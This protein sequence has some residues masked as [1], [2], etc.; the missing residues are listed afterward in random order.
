MY[1]HTHLHLRAIGTEVK[2]ID[3]RKVFQEDLKEL[4]ESSMTARNREFVG[5]GR[6]S[7]VQERLLTTGL[8]TERRYFGHSGVCSTVSGTFS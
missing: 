1:A 3:Y 6:W 5:S 7:L 2:V 4:T 8:S